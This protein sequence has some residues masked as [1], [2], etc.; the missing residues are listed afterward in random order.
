MEIKKIG[1]VGAGLMGA[2]MSQ[3][4]ACRGYGVVVYDAFESPLQN[5]S[6]FQLHCVIQKA[7][8]LRQSAIVY[9]NSFAAV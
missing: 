8:C 3:I 9:I 5:C 6:V 7:D 2:G 1:I 4:F